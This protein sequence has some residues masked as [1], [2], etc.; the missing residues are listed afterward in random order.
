[1]GVGKLNAA[2]CEIQI[3]RLRNTDLP[4]NFDLNDFFTDPPHHSYTV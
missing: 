4:M 1:M 2:L 3:N